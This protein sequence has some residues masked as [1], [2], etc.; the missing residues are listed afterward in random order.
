MNSVGKKAPAFYAKTTGGE[1][2]FPN[3]TKGSW[4]ILYFYTDDFAPESA[5]DILEIA[6]KL[7]KFLS[8]GARVYAI[9]TDSVPAHIAFALSLRNR[10]EDGTD[11]GFDL[12]SDS[13]F[14][15]SKSY[16][17]AGGSTEPQ[18][19]EKAVVI[20]DPDGVIRSFHRYAHSTGINVTEIERELIALQTGFAQNAITP[21][22]WTPG[23][24]IV[25]PPPETLTKAGSAVADREKAGFICN[26]WYLCYKQDTGLRS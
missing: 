22:G 4:T 24:D 18:L 12:V 20:I 19:N 7:G 5:L 2:I 17:V 23:E 13:N 14:E 10:K 9:S 26:D 21:A 3:N 16:G 25:G 6:K 15:I 11:V 1:L 8:Y